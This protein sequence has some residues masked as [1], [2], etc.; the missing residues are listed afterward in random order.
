MSSTYVLSQFFIVIAYSLF[1][2]SYVVKNRKLILLCSSASLVTEVVGY[3]LLS[4]WSGVGMVFV[5]AFR[6]ILFY[7]QVKLLEKRPD[8][9]KYEWVSLAI[10]WTVAICAAAITCESVLSTFSILSGMIYTLSIWQKNYRIYKYLGILA[11]LFLIAYNIFIGSLFGAI[12]ESALMI[13]I[14]ITAFTN[15]KITFVIK[16][17]KV[18]E[19]PVQIIDNSE[20]KN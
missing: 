13:W 6:N 17:K 8:L 1:A 5:A 18:E 3:I 11:C 12:L 15:I 14:I 20:M 2:V 10:V 7:G 4:A 19:V 9:A 16:K